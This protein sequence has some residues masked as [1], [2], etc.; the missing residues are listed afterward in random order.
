[1][2]SRQYG[3]TCNRCLR[4]RRVSETV[5]PQD[6]HAPTPFGVGL[7]RH[8][9]PWQVCVSTL[10]RVDP[11]DPRDRRYHYHTT[12]PDQHKFLL[13]STTFAFAKFITTH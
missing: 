4:W 7:P 11:A 6:D 8:L 12:G 3:Y 1:M 10:A 2:N 13:I 9:R 5:S